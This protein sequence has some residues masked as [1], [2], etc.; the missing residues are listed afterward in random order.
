MRLHLK[1]LCT[2]V[3]IG[4]GFAAVPLA[5]DGRLQAAGLAIIVG[6]FFDLAD[7]VVARVTH[8]QN[9]FGSELDLVA[10]LV[11][12]T[13]A[14][15]VV[16]FYAL[17]PL[18][19]PLAFVVGLLPLVFGCLR[20]ARFNVRKIEYPGFWIGLT[21]PGVAGMLI[22]YF[23]ST[24]FT[25]Y[26]SIPLSVVLVATVSVLNVSLIPYPGHHQRRWTI[27]L[28]LYAGFVVVAIVGA[29]L[30]GHAW[31]AM[32]AF[33]VL[34]LLSPFYLISADERARLRA[35]IRDWKAEEA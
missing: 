18:S 6:T 24:L 30:L 33:G 8:T 28:K 20:L 31:D 10:D 17:D 27:G 3:T 23:N 11:V 34:Y 29:A 26:R 19:R 25:T 9:R 22:A 13:F 21:R 14:S 15:S 12:Y 2:I 16:T 5:A 7:G 35:F 32:L 1:D 4:L